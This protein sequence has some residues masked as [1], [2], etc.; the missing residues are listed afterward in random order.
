MAAPGGPQL[1]PGS[2]QAAALPRLTSATNAMCSKVFIQVFVIIV[3]IIIIIIIIII[4]IIIIIGIVVVP[5]LSIAADDDDVSIYQQSRNS[6]L[7]VFHVMC[8]CVCVCLPL[9]VRACFYRIVKAYTGKNKNC[10]KIALFYT[11]YSFIHCI[12][13][14]DVI[15]Y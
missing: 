5:V 2:C 1:H 10:G 8:V 12:E 7:C 14:E 15:E 13:G 4:V 3:I 6:V 11:C 9:R